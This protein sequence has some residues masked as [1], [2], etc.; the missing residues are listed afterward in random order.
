MKLSEKY[1]NAGRSIVTDNFYTSITLA[2]NLLQ[3]S[4]HLIGTLRKNRKG[5]PK[6]VLKEKLKKGKVCAMENNDGVLIL[7]WKDKREVLALST[8]HTPG[9]V[10]VRSKRNRNKVT[11]KPT[12][13]A[14]YN[15]HKCS[16]DFTDQMG[17]YSN[18]ARRS[19]RWFQKLA[20]ELLFSTSMV[21][22]YILYKQ[23]KN[24]SSKKYT[25]TTF[26][27]NICRELMGLNK[28]SRQV[29]NNQTCSTRHRFGKSPLVDHRNRIVRRR[30]IHCYEKKREEGL[31]SVEACKVTKKVNTVCLVCPSHPSMCSEY[32]ANIHKDIVR[33]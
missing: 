27:E 28:N 30:C 31:S 22:A 8:R 17:S 20:I 19:L 23:V 32:F 15:S 2:Q 12:V 3:K 25:I 1:L 5:I 29:R 10:S 14:D 6:Y 9:F 11:M 4:T 18:P 7:R 21:N 16:I 13:I 33:Q 26:K 24:L